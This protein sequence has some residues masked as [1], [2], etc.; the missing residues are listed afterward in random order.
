[1]DGSTR[2]FLFS[3]TQELLMN[4]R[5]HAHASHVE[6]SLTAGN[7][8]QVIRVSDDGVGFDVPQ[9]LE[10]RPGHLGLAAL[11]ARVA[12]AGGVLRID[13]APGAG[14]T[15]EFEVPTSTTDT[16]RHR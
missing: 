15:V 10:V 1:L 14:A 4:V 5:K 8:R 16:A 13:T 3:I 11:T 2:G 12:D 9:A 6:V 7:G